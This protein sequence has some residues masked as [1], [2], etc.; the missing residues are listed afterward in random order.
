M[1]PADPGD[2]ELLSDVD[3]II[4]AHSASETKDLDP[5]SEI[6]FYKFRLPPGYFCSNYGAVGT[7]M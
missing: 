7:Y 4:L 3:E 5:A 1:D 6:L 2:P